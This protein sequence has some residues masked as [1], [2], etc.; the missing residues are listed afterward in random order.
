[1]PRTLAPRRVD[2]YGAAMDAEEHKRRIREAAANSAAMVRAAAVGDVDGL[3]AAAQSIMD[4]GAGWDALVTMARFTAA[5]IDVMTAMT[6]K[7]LDILLGEFQAFLERPA[8][9]L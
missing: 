5:T 3:G 9:N 1:M 2:V 7:S 4:E 6:D 8:E